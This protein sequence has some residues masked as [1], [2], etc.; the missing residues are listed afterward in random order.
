ML[1]LNQQKDY[2]IEFLH[3]HGVEDDTICKNDRN[4]F[5]NQ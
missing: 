1:T 3:L 5:L 4:V 2:L